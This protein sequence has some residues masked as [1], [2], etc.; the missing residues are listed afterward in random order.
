MADTESK[1]KTYIVTNDTNIV[2]AIMDV[3][4]FEPGDTEIELDE[5]QVHIMEDNTILKF[6][7]ATAT[8]NAKAVAPKAPV[9]VST[10][11]TE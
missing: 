6:K 10:D 8:A 4:R 2:Y 9:A 1:K 5:N 3:G 11:I 7:E